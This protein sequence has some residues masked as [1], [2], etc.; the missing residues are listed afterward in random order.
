MNIMGEVENSFPI[1]TLML[2]G[3][4]E[5]LIKELSLRYSTF[6]IDGTVFDVGVGMILSCRGV[7]V[8][9]RTILFRELTQEEKEEAQKI[10]TYQNSEKNFVNLPNSLV[11]WISSGFI[12]E[13]WNMDLY[14]RLELVAINPN[15]NP[16]LVFV[17]MK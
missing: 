16:P 5:T 10:T 8:T 4:A 9:S 11:I 1:P 17:E 15:F 3:K 14:S 12:T 6:Y 7:S 2:D 13:F